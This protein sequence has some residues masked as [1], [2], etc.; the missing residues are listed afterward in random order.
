MEGLK[1]PVFTAIGKVCGI[2]CNLYDILCSIKPICMFSKIQN[3]I[4]KVFKV[5]F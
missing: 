1:A 3:F 5:P 4:M 2:T